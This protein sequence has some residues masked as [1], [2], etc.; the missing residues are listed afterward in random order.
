MKIPLNDY[1]AMNKINAIAARRESSRPT[2]PRRSEKTPHS[3]VNYTPKSKHKNE[4][5]GVC[6]HF[7]P[8]AQCETVAPPIKASGWCI[9]FEK[10]K[11]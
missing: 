2:M 10:E 7:I 1:R 5:C 8:P 6:E 4:R 3:E 9:R 11:K